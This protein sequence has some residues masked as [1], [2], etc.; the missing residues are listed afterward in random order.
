MHGT[1]QV[2]GGSGQWEWPTVICTSGQWEWSVGVA[3]CSM[4]LEWS[5]GVYSIV[6]S[7]KLERTIWC[8]KH[9][10]KVCFVTP[11]YVRP[12]LF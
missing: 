7:R 8:A 12:R 2:S 9:A 3:Y 4:Y 11:S 1:P 5:V 6:R 10:E